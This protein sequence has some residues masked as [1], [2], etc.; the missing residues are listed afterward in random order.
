MKYIVILIIIL[1]IIIYYLNTKNKKE[2]FIKIT[3]TSTNKVNSIFNNCGNRAGKVEFDIVKIMGKLNNKPLNQILLDLAFPVGSF[4]VQF[5]TSGS[6][7][8][9]IAFPA[10]NSPAVLFGGDW[11]DQ[12][13]FESVYFRTPGTLANEN[14]VNGFQNYATKHLYGDS[15]HYQSNYWTSITNPGNSGV[16]DSYFLEVGT[17]DGRHADTVS[18]AYFD[19]SGY[20]MSIDAS[21]YS[22]SSVLETRVKNRIIKVWKRVERDASGNLPPPLANGYT[23][24]IYDQ[25][26]YD[27]PEQ[28]RILKTIIPGVTTFEGAMDFCNAKGEDCTHISS[29]IKNDWRYGKN[30]I[31]IAA[32]MQPTSN[33][34]LDAIENFKVWTKK[35]LDTLQVVDQGIK[36][37][38][39]IPVIPTV[40]I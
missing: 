28:H 3:T 16:F 7:V 19:T 11:Q 34:G 18:R 31:P 17:D 24:S 29:G 25:I 20:F 36:S 5:P 21:G 1:I 32:N 37:S 40:K 14:R 39:T 27:G 13:Q 15:T 26:Y 38:T 12:W 10:S 23:N 4:Y 6:N 22:N 8:S 9:S 35:N 2:N 30:E 33:I